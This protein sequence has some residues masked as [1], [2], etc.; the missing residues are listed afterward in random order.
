M[1]LSHAV[2]LAEARSHVAAL[3]DRSSFEAAME[4]ERV[5]LQLDY[6]HEGSVPPITV[7]PTGDRVVLLQSAR[8]AIAALGD[9]DVD[10]LGLAV[11]LH[12]LEV[13][14]ELDSPR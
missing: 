8:A 6:L 7:V 12:M 3:A 9:H 13:A 4:Y 2:Q 10:A 14:W 11:C 5:L 1:L